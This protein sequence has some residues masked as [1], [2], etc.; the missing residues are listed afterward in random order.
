M[1]H[2]FTPNVITATFYYGSGY[3]VINGI[4]S[5]QAILQSHIRDCFILMMYKNVTFV[6][7]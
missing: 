5:L 3:F 4:L 7:F 6:H 1:P 2:S